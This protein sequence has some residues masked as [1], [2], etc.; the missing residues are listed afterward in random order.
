M[1][2]SIFQQKT[3]NLFAEN[4]LLKTGFIV[5]L[6][7]FGLQYTEMADMRKHQQTIVVPVGASGPFTISGD[8]ADENY[9]RIM[10]TYIKNQA[11]NYT[12]SSARRNYNDLLP[13]YAPEKYAKAKDT[14][15]L[16]IAEIERFPNVTD[17]THWHGA[18]PVI[19]THDTITMSVKRV[20][21]IDGKEISTR[22]Q[23]WT[24]KYRIN[25]SKF[26]LLDLEKK[27]VS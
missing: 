12:A 24:I 4:R 19:F 13:L 8:K 9:I 25:N 20:R 22:P 2:L 16:L 23:K 21:Y 10:A 18:D 11:G 14:F 6:L 15:L 27:N 1:K 3:S 26:E 5:L 17:V 7:I